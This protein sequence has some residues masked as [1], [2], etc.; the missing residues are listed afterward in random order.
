[1]TIA[2]AP[3]VEPISN[4]RR[5]HNAVLSKLEKGPVFLSQHGTLTAALVSIEQWNET[6]QTIQDLKAQLAAERRLRITFGRTASLT[7]RR[8][9][10][11]PGGST[12]TTSAPKSASI[13]AA[14]GP[15]MLWEKSS[16]VTPSSAPFMGWHRT[17]RT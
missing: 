4:L 11:P 12:P 15:A 16:T 2:K 6:A 3:Q 13:V 8:W 10:A 7:I 17:T 9:P 14:Y 5:E 1:M